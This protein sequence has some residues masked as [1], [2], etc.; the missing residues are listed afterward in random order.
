M[1]ERR[2]DVPGELAEEVAEA[3]GRGAGQPVAGAPAVPASTPAAVA[4]Q[5]LVGHD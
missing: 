4:E 3:G 5:G 1:V 2:R